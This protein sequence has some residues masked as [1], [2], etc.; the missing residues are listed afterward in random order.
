MNES[1]PEHAKCFEVAAIV[2]GEEV[3]RGC[4]SSKKRAEQEAAKAAYTVLKS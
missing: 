4:G 1:G 2:D 3:S